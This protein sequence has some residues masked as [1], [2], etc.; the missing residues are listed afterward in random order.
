MQRNEPTNPDPLETAIDRVIR[1]WLPEHYPMFRPL[2]I[3]ERKALL[4]ESFKQKALA[5]LLALKGFNFL[6]LD[7]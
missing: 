4:E 1:G 6:P 7:P 5:G 2:S 3:A